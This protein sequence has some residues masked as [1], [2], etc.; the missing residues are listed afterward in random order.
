M[1]SQRFP[2]P[3]ELDTL[4]QEQQDTLESENSEKHLSII[5]PIQH[6]PYD[7]LSEIFSWTLPHLS[8]EEFSSVDMSLSPWILTRICSRWRDITLSLPV[9]WAQ[10]HLFGVRRTKRAILVAQL[11]RSSPCHLVIALTS[12]FYDVEA[13]S[14]LTEYSERWYA[15]TLSLRAWNTPLLDNVSGCMPLL[16]SLTYYDA[17]AACTAFEAAPR[18]RQVINRSFS[19]SHPPVPF[20]QLVRLRHPIPRTELATNPLRLADSLTQLSLTSLVWSPFPRDADNPI[21]LPRLSVL[22]IRNGLFLD[23]MVLPALE[24]IWV[25]EN[26][27]ALMS[28][29]RRSSCRLRKLLTPRT[30]SAETISFLAQ[31]SSLFELYCTDFEMNIVSRLALPSPED[32][33]SSLLVPELQILYLFFPHNTR[34]RS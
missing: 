16:F 18:L 24:D 29:V 3:L 31:N 13:F 22:F 7:V 23:H 12:K 17:I 9:L 4:R 11:E 8:P 5:S 25:G 27:L 28:L 33:D 30:S 1:D 14:L 21:T 2:G 6:L 10:I 34:L 15:I 26:A 20:A 32:S 19:H